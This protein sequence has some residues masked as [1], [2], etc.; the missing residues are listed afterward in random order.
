M[1]SGVYLLI[2]AGVAIF[3]GLYIY[4]VGWRKKV[5]TRYKLQ[6]MAVY[7]CTSFAS[8]YILKSDEIAGT[9]GAILSILIGLG[10]ALILIRPGRQSRRRRRSADR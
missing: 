2:I 9:Q 6:L 10:V 5:M 8:L 3:A 1:E 7:V 4:E